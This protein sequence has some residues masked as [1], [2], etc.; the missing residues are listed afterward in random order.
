[1][2]CGLRRPSEER[3][4]GNERLP[5]PRT[6]IGSS[7]MRSWAGN[8]ATTHRKKRARFEGWVWALNTQSVSVQP[9]KK[10]LISQCL[11]GDKSS[12]NLVPC[13]E[14]SDYVLLPLN[15]IYILR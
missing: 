4:Y 15:A 10:K 7:E 6:C 2:L 11:V 3:Q 13:A 12:E 14:S 5:E 9:K 1:M 8:F